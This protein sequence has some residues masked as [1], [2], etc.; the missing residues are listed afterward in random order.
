M[1]LTI[2]TNNAVRLLMYC[3]LDPSELSK[4]KDIA[5][6]VN[7]SENHLSKIANLLAQAGIIE[8][9][10]G[11]NGGLRLARTPDQISLGH[12]ARVTDEGVCLV[13]CFDTETNTCP[14][15]DVC[16]FGGVLGKALAAFYAVLD[17]HSLS[18]ILNDD[19]ALANAMGLELRAVA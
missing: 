17:N 14:L 6:A 15:S 18:D 10:R 12:V 7:A 19:A 4:S 3:A 8:T 1:R 11:R 16:Q 9:V 2:K 5:K 13:E